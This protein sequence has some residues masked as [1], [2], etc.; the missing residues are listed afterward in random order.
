MADPETTTDPRTPVQKSC[1][2]IVIGGG[3]G[4]AAAAAHLAR[5]GL[6]T[7]L[8]EKDRHP[9][10][11]IGE[12]L[13]P[14]SMPLLQELGVFDRV[15]EIGVHKSGAEFV[16]D[17][18]DKEVIFDFSRALFD[19][20]DHAYQVR[21]SEFDHILFQRAEQEGALTLEETSAKVLSLDADRAVVRTES[22][23]GQIIDWT[24][25]FLADASG[26]STVTSKM[27]DQKRPDPRNTS[28]AIFG[29]FR[30]IPRR[31]DARGGN[32]RIH[33]TN[34]GWM[35]QIPL[36]DGVTSVGFVA[37]GR[38]LRE[39]SGGIEELFSQHC[40]RHPHVG[41]MIASAER[42]GPLRSTGNFS[43][44]ATEAGGDR[45]IKIG[46]AYGFI[47][48]V[49]STGVH[50]ALT[51]AREAADVIL[52]AQA[53]PARRHALIERY[54]RAIRKRMSFVSWFIYHINDP[55]FRHL[56]LNPQNILGIEQAVVSLL[57]GDF[58]WDPR[59][60][61]RIA[62]FKLVRYLHPPGPVGGQEVKH[63]G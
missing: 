27:L 48:P 10:F 63:A 54:D 23:D 22:A 26:R 62:L 45:H 47:D 14:Y 38:Y 61:W 58:R 29:H 20:P 30:G 55:T 18:G 19:G 2:V 41:A 1:D 15:R 34:P 11:H 8:V 50:L 53:R 60:R 42:D 17:D 46:D 5:A 24:T 39:R 51:S 25:E 32:I 31:Q 37:P 43:Y 4:G 13:L 57:A 44:R 52:K 9:R 7:V 6:N 3:P 33:L 12:S 36:R 59:L 28:A 16:S 56:M 21:R 40:A 49:F 35:W